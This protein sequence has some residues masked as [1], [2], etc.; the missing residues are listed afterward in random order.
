VRGAETL[1]DSLFPKPLQP[2]DHLSIK[3]AYHSRVW[4]DYILNGQGIEVYEPR[5]FYTGFRYVE[6]TM[7]NHKDP[8]TLEVEGRV[9]RSALEFNGR[10]LTSD[11]LLNRIHRATIWS[12]MGNIHGFPTDCPHREKGGY[13]GD[14]QIIAESSIHDFHMAAFYTKWLNDMRDAQE[15]YGRIPNTSPTLIG[16]HGGGI[17]WGSA[18]ILLPFWM[19]QY[20]NDTRIL[21]EHYITMK[22]Y[23]DYLHNLANTDSGRILYYK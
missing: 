8:E 1:N 2:G 13:T 15:E 11:S 20:Y 6:V 21:E 3:H 9:V 7:D 22:R 12:Q 5:F 18:Y 16:G 10:F 19:Y 17:A 23:L 14:G 4:T